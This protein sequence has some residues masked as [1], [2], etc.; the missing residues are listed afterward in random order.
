VHKGIEVAF[1]RD[2]TRNVVFEA[3]EGSELHEVPLSLGSP[4]TDGQRLRFPVLAG[5]LAGREDISI[6]LHDLNGKREIRQVP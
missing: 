6:V 2:I 5:P 4:E 1:E 3:A